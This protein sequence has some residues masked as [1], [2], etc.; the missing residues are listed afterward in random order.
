MI[1]FTPRDMRGSS[2]W[3]KLFMKGESLYKLTT[4]LSIYFLRSLFH[5]LTE[6]RGD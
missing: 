1:T 3:E 2:A 6:K 5:V 4:L